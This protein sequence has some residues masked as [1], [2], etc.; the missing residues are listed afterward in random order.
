MVDLGSG[1]GRRIQ[2]EHK[3]GVKGRIMLG[4]VFVFVL[5]RRNSLASHT[6]ERRP[7]SKVYSSEISCWQ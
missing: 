2:V 3:A 6:V 1:E 4:I 7:G 5:N